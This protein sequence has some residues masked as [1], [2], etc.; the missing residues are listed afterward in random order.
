MDAI[1]NPEAR[2]LTWST[3]PVFTDRDKA[4]LRNHMKKR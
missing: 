3:P 2:F 1:I 4:I